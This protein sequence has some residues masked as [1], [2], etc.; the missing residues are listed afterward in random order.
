MAMPEL[1]CVGDAVAGAST[2]SPFDCVVAVGPDFNWDEIPALKAAVERRGVLDATTT[3]SLSLIAADG[4]A[5]GRLVLSPTGPL[6]RD[7]DDVR[8]FFDAARAGLCRAR[9]AGSRRPFLVVG[10][11][12]ADDRYKRAVEVAL[13]GALGGLWE[14][15]EGREALGEQELE[16]VEQ[17]GFAAPPWMDGEETGRWVT[18]IE[19][20]RRVARDIGGTEPERMAPA[21]MA[22]YCA[23]HVV[24]DRMAMEVVDSQDELLAHYPLLSAVAR[25][26]F[27]VE[28]HR[29]RVIRLRYEGGG[30]ICRT[31]L[32]AG[33]GLTYDTGGADIKAGGH[34]A[35]MSRDK[36]GAA[37]VAGFMRTVRDLAP[38]G[39]RV[40]AEIGAVRNSVGADAY[41]SDEIIRSHAGCRVRIGNTDAEGRLVLAD[42]LS[43][44]REEALRSP[45]P[46]IFSVAT[47]TGHSGR[48]VGAYSSAIDNGPARSA[49]ISELMGR[50]GDEWGDPFDPQRMRREDWDFVKPRTRADDVLSC[51]NAPS[52][53]TARGHQF[54]MAFLALASGLSSHGGDSEHPVAY[55]HMDVGGSAMEGG[56][57]QHGRPTGAPLLT[58]AA[59]Y[60]PTPSRS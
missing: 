33:K 59:A 32:F 12:P 60:L 16:P 56:D 52:V 40:I 2:S 53:S 21:R 48:A 45:E 10:G 54:P 29:P 37:A 49:G 47:L 11:I 34:M 35:G 8:R 44:L 55:T 51:N 15:L 19:A 26:S 28:R 58:L 30:E 13:L 46:H 9:D 23:E 27:G 3:S 43:H 4:L 42:L 57:W 24:G 25:A 39:I 41:V 18:A 7:Y 36:G 38:E 20:G 50:L 1:I 6:S 31:L 5:G 14:P 17:V 22:E